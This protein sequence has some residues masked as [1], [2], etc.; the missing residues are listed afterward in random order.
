MDDVIM[1]G[2]DSVG[3]ARAQGADDFNRAQQSSSSSD[4]HHDDESANAQHET[5]EQEGSQ[6]EDLK[7][8]YP[9][10]RHGDVDQ[11]LSM[12]S[13]SFASAVTKLF[14]KQA[15]IRGRMTQNIQGR[16]H[17]V[18]QDIEDA[19]RARK[20]AQEMELT[21]Q[22]DE[23]DGIKKAVSGRKRTST[24]AND[25]NGDSSAEA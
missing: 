10:P 13:K 17:S 25:A 22:I 4:H 5:S 20:Q 15:L 24:M 11:D 7:D 2:E 9:S 12:A 8:G 21:E 16:L 6:V 19:V 14:A 23:D 3:D 1:N 18:L